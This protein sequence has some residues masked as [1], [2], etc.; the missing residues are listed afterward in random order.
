LSLSGRPAILGRRVSLRVWSL[1][2]ITLALRD[3]MVLISVNAVVGLL[4]RSTCIR[5]RTHLVVCRYLPVCR[6]DA[7]PQS[8]GWLVFIMVYIAQLAIFTENETECKCPHLQHSSS[9]ICYHVSLVPEYCCQRHLDVYAALSM[10]F[11]STVDYD[12]QCVSDTLTDDVKVT[13]KVTSEQNNLKT[14]CSETDDRGTFLEQVASV[15]TR[16]VVE[17]EKQPVFSH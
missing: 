6:I 3:C 9:F 2:Q 15:Q 8:R 16:A 17:K 1:T 14:K 11:A 10:E 4:Q 5:D 13:Q 7:E 12:W